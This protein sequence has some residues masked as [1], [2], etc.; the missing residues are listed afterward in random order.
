MAAAGPDMVSA[1]QK[2]IEEES[3]GQMPKDIPAFKKLSWDLHPGNSTP[4][5]LVTS[6]HMGLLASR[7]SKEEIIFVF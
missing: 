4:I 2:G 6:C 3:N 5:S 7:E 1:L